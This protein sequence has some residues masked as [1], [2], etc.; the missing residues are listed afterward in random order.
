MPVAAAMPVVYRV[1]FTSAF[2]PPAGR[3]VAEIL[4]FTPSP[5]E[6]IVPSYGGVA[7]YL[8]HVQGKVLERIEGR[9]VFVVVA[10]WDDRDGYG[11]ERRLE[12]I[13]YEGARREMRI[14]RCHV[15]LQPF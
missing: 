2:R 10:W 6:V 11:S 7:G 8:G 14:E 5:K 9:R 13:R 15:R 4:I 12:G 3:T 1:A